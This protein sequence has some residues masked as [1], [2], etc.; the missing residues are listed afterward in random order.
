M[1]N[2]FANATL[3]A[4]VLADGVRHLRGAAPTAA[5]VLEAGLGVAMLALAAL[6]VRRP[7]PASRDGSRIAWVVVVASAIVPLLTPPATVALPGPTALRVVGGVGLVTSL[8]ALGDRFALLPQARGIVS[9]GPY[10][11]VRHPLYASYLLI[12][13]ADWLATGAWPQAVLWLLAGALFLARARLEEDCLAQRFREYDD[14]R[15]RVRF[16]LL[17][18]II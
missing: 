14:Y 12:E 11:I 15:R 3:A 7:P 16:R 9:R 2:G 13:L 5:G 1:R 17:P 8:L 10:A 4:L 18:G 6:I